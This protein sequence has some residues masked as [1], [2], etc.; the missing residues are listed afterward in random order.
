[1]TAARSWWPRNLKRPSTTSA[2]LRSA[3]PSGILLHQREQIVLHGSAV[4][5]GDKAVLFCGPSGA[6]KSTMAAAL[7]QRAAFHWYR[8]MSVWSRRPIPA[9]R[10]SIPT[11]AS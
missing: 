2:S 1:M 4:R 7:V 11:G 5:V 3:A 6:E 8:K 9:R 10:P